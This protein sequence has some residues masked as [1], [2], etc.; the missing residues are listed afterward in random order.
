MQTGTTREYDPWAVNRSRL[1]KRCVCRGGK[2]LCKKN[3]LHEFIYDLGNFNPF[4][5]HQFPLL[6]ENR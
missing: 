1:G 2:K 6:D 5:F 4:I 3:V